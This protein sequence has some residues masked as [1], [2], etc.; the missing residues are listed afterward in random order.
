MGKTG[1]INF[2]SFDFASKI[3]GDA[4]FFIGEE[5]SPTD[6]VDSGRTLLPDFYC[7]SLCLDG[8]YSFESNSRRSTCKKDDLLISRPGEFHRYTGHSESF[9]AIFIA[10]KTDF[11]ITANG[12]A[13]EI[14]ALPVLRKGGPTVLPLSN[15]LLG[16]I[17]QYFAKLKLLMEDGRRNYV[18]DITRNVISAMLYELSMNFPDGQQPQPNSMT[19]A[20]QITHSFELLLEANFM[21]HRMIK[22]YAGQLFITPAYLS[23]IL[24]ETRGKNG[25]QMIRDK[26]IFEIEVRLRATEDTVSKIADDFNYSNVTAL[27]RFFK[28]NKQIS[29]Q[30][31]R[32]AS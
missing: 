24:K 12:F 18:Q 26:V 23:E 16:C 7:I 6:I 31:F 2:K 28:N 9:K 1:F 22:F 17:H 30:K 25:T 10:F 21:R 3:S 19:R 11:F 14:F 20:N 8:D 13:H 32:R 27:I 29:P 4:D 15:F 5:V